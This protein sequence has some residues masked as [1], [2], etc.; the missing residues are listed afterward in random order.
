MMNHFRKDIQSVYEDIKA[1]IINDV[2]SSGQPLPEEPLAIQYGI[3]RTR[4]RQILQE[5]ENECLV[6]RFPGKGAFVKNITSKD[7]QEIFEMREALEGMASRLAARRREDDTLETIIELFE[8]S[9]KH[10]ADTELENY[11]EIGEK[12][13]QFILQSCSNSMIANTM[14]RLRTSIMRIWKGGLRIPGRIDKAF[15]EH[16]EIL[17]AIKERDEDVAE[18]RMRQH[19]SSAFKE[20]IEEIFLH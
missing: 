9:E 16:K 18:Q 6:D 17:S 1:K 20:Y 11:I 8:R 13:H 5:L 14:E 19:I 3:K 12:L 7:L 4:I 10:S 2:Y 15:E